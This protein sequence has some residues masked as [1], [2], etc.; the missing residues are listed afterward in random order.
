MTFLVAGAFVGCSKMPEV[1]KTSTTTGMNLKAGKPQ[2]AVPVVNTPEVTGSTVK[3]SWAKVENAADY[4][5]VFA[6]TSVLDAKPNVTGLSVELFDVPNGEY[7][8][9]VK[10]NSASKDYSNSEFST[11]ISFTVAV[12]KTPVQKQPLKT[13]E[14]TPSV[15]YSSASVGTV[16]ANPSF[17]WPPNNKTINVV[18]SGTLSLGTGTFNVSWGAVENAV[19]YTVLFNGTSEVITETS[20]SKSGLAP[21]I[22]TVS[23]VANPA[24]ASE[25]YLPSDPAVTNAEILPGSA[26][27]TL[28]DEYNICSTKGVLSENYNV[29]LPLVASRLGTD[30]DGRVYTFTVTATNGGGVSV[31]GVA[32]STVPHDQRK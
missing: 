27:Y 9:K 24:T 5:V 3:I 18:F 16:T 6:G 7:T 22:Y 14:L 32:T 17:I 13:P 23:V 8:V 10:A 26:K 15:I 2:I 12:V 21:G 25:L 29:S 11:S 1:P 20:W 4:N 28:A 19:N 30:M 31:T